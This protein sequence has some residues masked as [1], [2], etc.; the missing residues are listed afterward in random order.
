[1]F[2]STTTSDYSILDRPPISMPLVMDLSSTKWKCNNIEIAPNCPRCAS[3]NTK[4]CY[5]NNYSL[6]QPRYF[7][8]ACRRYWTKGGSLRNVPVGGGCRKSR[9]AR[10]TTRQDGAHNCVSPTLSPGGGQGQ[11]GEL[12]N[13]TCIDVAAVYAKYVNHDAGVEESF[14]PGA[15]SGSSEIDSHI[16][17]VTMFD[18]RMQ[19]VLP[20]F[21]VH[22]G[23]DG[24]D[25][26]YQDFNA[27]DQMAQGM[28]VDEIR[29]DV[30]WSE[31]TSL[32]NFGSNVQPAMQVQDFGLISPDDDQFRL[33]ENLVADN[34]GSFDLSAYEF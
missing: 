2:T 7:C 29:A 33:P 30:L 13:S 20:Q 1:M 28:I 16:K 21:S 32:S 3:T 31:G 4:F 8:K 11:A 17:D 19:H 6:S 22:Q 18:D 27:F 25:Y 10:A 26:V 9:R 5:Y 24:Q 34:W 12:G 15:S 23:M 14:C